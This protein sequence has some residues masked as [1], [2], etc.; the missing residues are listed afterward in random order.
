MIRIPNV[1]RRDQ[2]LIKFL[3]QNK[4]SN[5]E[6]LKEL[7]TT[8]KGY[9]LAIFLWMHN[10][11]YQYDDPKV[12]KQANKLVELVLPKIN[13]LTNAQIE[14]ILLM[15]K[16]LKQEFLAQE[17][18]YVVHND[19]FYD[20]TRSSVVC[21]DC[22]S[23]YC[24]INNVQVINTINSCLTKLK[25]QELTRLIKLSNDSYARYDKQTE[26][27]ILTNDW[28]QKCYTQYLTNFQSKDINKQIDKYI[29]QN[30]K[31]TK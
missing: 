15:H 27:V 16:T 25:P 11:V 18:W 20:E 9:T 23:K 14:Q 8:Q 12:L 6:I 7:E 22:S 19:I 26:K 21:L 13:Q 1:E 31:G 24:D 29:K 10:F 30:Q 3:N 5:Q 2:Y 4:V 17:Q 28:K